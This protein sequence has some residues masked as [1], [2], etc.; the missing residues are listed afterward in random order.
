MENMEKWTYVSLGDLDN[1][2]RDFI[3]KGRLM[4]DYRAWLEEHLGTQME[5]WAYWHGDRYAKGVYIKEPQAATAF[6]LTFKL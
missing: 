5:T 2:P 4:D 6:K 1:D 3:V